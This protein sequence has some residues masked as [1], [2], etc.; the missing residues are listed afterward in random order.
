MS[1]SEWIWKRE[2]KRECLQLDN[3]FPVHIEVS[4]VVILNV[5]L[6]C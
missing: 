2:G 3:Y 1:L 6:P 5:F 4:I